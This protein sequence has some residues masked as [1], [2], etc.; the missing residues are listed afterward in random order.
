MSS[1][2]TAVPRGLLITVGVAAA[3]GAALGLQAFN[4]VVGPVFLALLLSIVVQPVRRFPARH[5][6]PALL[7]TV[8]SL[9]AVYAMVV[10]LVAI[11]VVSGV[12]LAGL[13]TDYAPQFE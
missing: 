5:G 1:S 11:L 13:L 7:G 8:L 9:V 4:E 12:Q 2:P 3:L 10:A 6:L